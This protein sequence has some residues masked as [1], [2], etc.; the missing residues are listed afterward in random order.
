[1]KVARNYFDGKVTMGGGHTMG[2][3]LG[4]PI[5]PSN[6]LLGAW[7]IPHWI[8]I[9]RHMP[10]PRGERPGRNLLTIIFTGRLAWVGTL[11]GAPQLGP[12]IIPSNFL[13]GA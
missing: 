3:Q 12:P 6:F 5:I 9:Y 1:M 2:P 11:W 10:A 7:V 13:L 4:P 8:A